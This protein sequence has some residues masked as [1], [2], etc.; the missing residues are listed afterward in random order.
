M[1]ANFL[2][3]H[4]YQRCLFLLTCILSI[5]VLNFLSI[6]DANGQDSTNSTIT[7]GVTTKTV[8]AGPQYGRNSFH[9]WLW[10]KHYRKEWTTPVV[11]KILSLDS[12]SGGLTAYEAGG[13]RQSK[14]L[15]LKDPQGKEW[16]LRSIDKS[17]GKALP[18]IYR[19]TFVEGIIDDQVSIG[20]P[21]SAVTVPQMAKAA[22]IYHTNPTIASIPEQRSLGEFNKE[23]GNDLYLLE[24]RPDGDWNEAPNFGNSREI[25]STEKMFEKVFSKPDHRIDQNLFIRSRLFDMFVGDWGRHEDQWR[26]ASIEENGK[27]IYKPIPRDRDQAYTK[28]DGVL[29]SLF[30]GVAGINHVQ[31]FSKDI[32]NIKMYN[33][34]ARHLDRQ[35]AN[36]TTREQWISTAKELQQQLT[37]KIIE[38]AVKQLPPEVYPIS[39]EELT[40][41][42]KSRR[43]LL[44][45]FAY[46]YFS[47]LT[48]EVEIVGT[49]GRERFEV[50][51]VGDTET[52][53]S[54][55]DLSKEG[56][57]KSEPFYSRTFKNSET[58]EIRL[59]GLDDK[60]E[61]LI[62]TKP[63]H[64]IRIRV[65]GGPARDVYVDSA[66]SAGKNI[67]IYDNA[68]NDFRLSPKTKL[69]LSESDSIHVFRY[70]DFNYHK[71][72]FK[73]IIFY[74]NE[75]RLYVG[76]GYKVVTDRWRKEPF[77]SSHEAN[78]KYSLMENA[79][80]TEYKGLV[81]RFIGKWNLGL[82]GNYDWI[83]WINYFGIGNET[84]REYT[85]KEYRDYYRMRTR[86]LLTSVGLYR[87]FARYHNVGV[88]AYYQTYDI[89]ED[90][91]RYVAEHPT[92]SNGDDYKLKNFIGARVEYLFQKVDDVILPTRGWRFQSSATY[93]EDIQESAKSFARFASAITVYVPLS[94]SFVYYLK[95]GGATAT[96][97]PEFYQLNV[98][99]GGQTLRGYRRFR[100]YG[101]TMF[102]GQN[103]IQWIKDVRW[104][105]F[106]GRAGLLGLVDLGRVWQPGEESD[107]LHISFGGGF[108]LAPFNKISV[109][110]TFAKSK[111]D[112]TVNFRFGRTF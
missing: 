45:K 46:D 43:N 110:A 49:K 17:F 71:K 101:K 52:N 12:V 41:K 7:S 51:A 64:S 91:G 73:K 15:K 53:I 86:Q 60:D 42:L 79:F 20:H 94:N 97:T 108:I 99:G 18:E 107:K 58:R 38:D 54:L 92:N 83:R 81:T 22:G 39:G 68:D 26:W 33:F 37:D 67:S 44:E 36:E 29:L 80:S 32:K 69:N 106:N 21:Y 48:R 76:L 103:E 95:V 70:D 13:G 9:Q 62:N 105:L 65:I 59:Y 84:K 34:S 30:L 55:Y 100:F 5:I 25:I 63:R 85:G 16:V 72:G 19:E 87:N 66:L 88:A 11:I 102:H 1:T 24:Q 35:A 82:Y 89:L 96:G 56:E 23:F 75:D 14:S 2:H 57:L 78:T 112:A 77:A 104:N 47:V 31:T 50:N 93:T 111:E 61:Y 10:G 4:G 27:T 109:A 74:S 98:L 6:S 28:F 40:V 3:M 90:E 8:I